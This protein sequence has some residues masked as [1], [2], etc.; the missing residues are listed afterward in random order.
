MKQR[1][2]ALAAAVLFLLAAPLAAQRPITIS[3]DDHS[4]AAQLARD[5]VARGNY[6][7][8]DRDTV[9][10]ATFHAPGDV[11]IYDAD[12]RLEG[13]I[14]GRVAV[15]GGNFFIR[16]HA[17]VRGDIALLG[18][19]V[20]SSA[21]AT[22]G[23]VLETARGSRVAITGDSAM[24]D[25]GEYSARIIE[26]MKAS[27][28]AFFPRPLPA[29]DRVNG[30]TLSAGARILP[31]RN[32]SGPRI[33]IW[34]SYRFENPDKPGGGLRATVPLGVQNVQVVGEASRA[35]RTNDAWQR[36]DLSN[37]LSVLIYGRDFRDYWDADQ[38]RVMVTRPV[39]KPLIAGESWLS[40]RGGVLWSRDR[41]L[42]AH[43]V[44][45]F[46]RSNDKDRA[47]PPILD[48]TIVSAFAGT[49][50]R[51]VGRVSSFTSDVQVERSLSAPFDSSFTQLVGEATYTTVAFRT[52]T[53]RVYLR[54]LTPLGGD[55]P[56]QRYEILGGPTTL[57]TLAVGRYRG[58][59][60]AF[61]DARYGIPLPLQ[62]PFVGAPSL[63]LLYASGAAWTGA[64]SPRWTQN[65][66]VGL[67]FAL[68]SVAV[69]VDPQDPKPRLL[70][71]AAVPGVF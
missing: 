68:A 53:L 43:H 2:A 18:G 54:G 41:S 36:G 23:R 57:P 34:G 12:V 7:R 33:D 22:T 42:R 29:Y 47:N 20:Y 35:T 17:V 60:L 50:L 24:E 5:V 3:G 15:I 39:G 11:V 8:F 71:T 25:A 32:D 61:A 13:T 52:H 69:Y 64:H 44:F 37:S 21:L 10:P 46:W 31:T 63:Q 49:G 55:A 19:E 38:A 40:P 62:L 27:L 30:L 16:P 26:P 67:L 65:A 4:E 45:S 14:E 59:H 51:M 56:P 6:L 28:I 58:D 70:V 9:L 48:G 1:R 66:G